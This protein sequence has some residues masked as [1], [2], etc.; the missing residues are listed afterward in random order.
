MRTE[1]AAV[2]SEHRAVANVLARPGELN[3]QLLQQAVE[4]TTHL[5]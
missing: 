2:L 4:Q 1:S 3:S 5:M